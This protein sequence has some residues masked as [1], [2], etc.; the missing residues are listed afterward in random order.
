MAK[1]YQDND[2]DWNKYSESYNKRISAISSSSIKNIFSP[3]SNM[4][5]NF[6]YRYSKDMWNDFN[7]FEYR[8]DEFKKNHD[9]KHIVF[10]GCSETE[11]ADH[12]LDEAWAYILYKKI[13]EKEKLS[14]YYNL[15][16]SGHGITIQVLT[17]ME[18]I[19]KFNKPDEIF[20]LIPET[21]RTMLYLNGSNSGF[22]AINLRGS[23]DSLVIDFS[24]EHFV[25]AH[26]N[27]IISLKFLESYCKEAKIKLFW[28]TW[29]AEEEILL[30][31]YGFENYFSLNMKN[32]QTIIE[33]NFKKYEDKTK[34][35]S[36]NLT[37]N[38][39]HKGLVFHKYW[40]EQFYN[41]REN[42]KNN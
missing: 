4:N 2:F 9:N 17:L 21:V 34:S 24:E 12:G 35:V 10:M 42:E 23:R 5:T 28:S 29:Y 14:G 27:S 18:Y 41:R 37:K 38:D 30:D 1:R 11:G 33:N 19:N 32:A 13:S 39:G 15:A 6:R 7:S 40:A 8:S 25:N 22:H 20:F 3:M 26:F 31:S 16:V 36:Y